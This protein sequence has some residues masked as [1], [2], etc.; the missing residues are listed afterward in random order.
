MLLVLCCVALL[1]KFNA[2]PGP[3]MFPLCAGAVVTVITMTYSFN[4]GG[5]INP[6]RDFS[7]RL[8]TAIAGWG[9]EVFTYAEFS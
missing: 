7:P 1:D 5:A 9:F 2:T 6:A 4:C 8:F 3:G